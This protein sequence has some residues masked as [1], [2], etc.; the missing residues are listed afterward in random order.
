MSGLAEWFQKPHFQQ[1]NSTICLWHKKKG[2]TEA[3][4]ERLGTKPFRPP[5]A[6]QGEEG[7]RAQ[8]RNGELGIPDPPYA[9]SQGG[10]WTLRT[11]AGQVIPVLLSQRGLISPQ[12]RGETE[13]KPPPT[14]HREDLEAGQASV[15]CC[16]QQR[17]EA[18]CL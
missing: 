15:P 1:A 17:A 6:H 18:L 13:E 16:P 10:L 3:P 2:N 7:G 12:R 4:S 9:K 14:L 5:T 8:G 11:T